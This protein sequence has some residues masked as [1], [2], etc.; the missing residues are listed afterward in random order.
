MN[1]PKIS[2]DTRRLFAYV[3]LGLAVAGG[4]WLRTRDANESDRKTCQSVLIEKQRL[5][6]VIVNSQSQQ[7][8]TV[9]PSLPESIQKLI[10]DAIEQNARFLAKEQ[11]SFGEP[12]PICESVGINSRIVLKNSEGVPLGGSV[13][14][15][16]TTT[17]Q[18][19]SNAAGVGERGPAGPQG[20]P[21]PSGPSGSNGSPSSPTTAPAQPSQ[22]PPP[23]TQPVVVICVGK[24]CVQ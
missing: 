16:T 11:D 5:A 24:F 9:D 6:D 19:T 15:T 2:K 3:L 23:T 4:F 22:P 8:L 17:P 7:T 13:P 10:R 12:I 21:G 1:I 14:T 20:Q 18:A